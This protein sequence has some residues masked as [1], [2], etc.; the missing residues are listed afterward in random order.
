MYSKKTNGEWTIGTKINTSGFV[1]TDLTEI[2]YM[3]RTPNTVTEKSRKPL[4]A[5]FLTWTR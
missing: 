4:E 3:P 5:E 2:T 1:Q